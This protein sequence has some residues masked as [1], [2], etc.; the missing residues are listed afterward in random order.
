MGYSG[1][2]PVKQTYYKGEGKTENPRRFKIAVGFYFVMCAISFATLTYFI[3][4]LIF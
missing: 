2:M 3:L 4:D 1:S